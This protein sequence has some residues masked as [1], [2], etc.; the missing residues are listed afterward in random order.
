MGDG[1]ILLK[2]RRTSLFND[3][4]SNEA[5]FGRIHPLDSTFKLPQIYFV[6]VI[7]LAYRRASL[8]VLGKGL[9]SK[10]QSVGSSWS[11]SMMVHT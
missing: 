7:F 2:N 10:R 6:T 5:N 3:D 1:R 4:L 11:D 9:N 8:K